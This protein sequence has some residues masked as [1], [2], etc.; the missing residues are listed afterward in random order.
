MGRRL[1]PAKKYPA[2]FFFQQDFAAEFYR[3]AHKR[4][5]EEVPPLRAA[6]PLDPTMTSQAPSAVSDDAGTSSDSSSEASVRVEWGTE[7]NTGEHLLYSLAPVNADQR[8]GKA[9]VDALV[10]DHFPVTKTLYSVLLVPAL[11]EVFQCS[12]TNEKA[13]NKLM[14]T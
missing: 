5:G 14:A 1:P 7:G 10:D 11:N 8:S 4:E 3:A 6:L 13:L 2:R 12:K 9:I